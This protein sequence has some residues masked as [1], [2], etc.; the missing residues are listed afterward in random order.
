MSY[1]PSPLYHNGLLYVLNDDGIITC[2]DATNGKPHFSQRLGGDYSASPLLLGDRI[3]LSSEQGL[4][5][6]IAAGKKYQ[7]LGQL[8]L[9]DSIFATA[10]V[11]PDGVYVRTL[12]KLVKF[13]K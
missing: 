9:V 10:A 8:D 7:Q 1:V 2:L 11:G 6:T 3:V 5:T 13:A 4:V 12:K